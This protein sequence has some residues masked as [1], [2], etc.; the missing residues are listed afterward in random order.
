MLP[1]LG[2][3]RIRHDEVP[4]AVF[5]ILTKEDVKKR[6]LEGEVCP[7]THE[8]LEANRRRGQP[9]AT[10]RVKKRGGYD[11]YDAEALAQSVWADIKNKRRPQNPA[12]RQPLLNHDI[13]QLKEAFP[14]QK[15]PDDRLFEAIESRDRGDVERAIQAGASVR[16]ENDD[17]LMPLSMW[18]ITRN[19]PNQILF[20]LREAPDFDIDAKLNR[21]EATALHVAAMFRA[22]EPPPPAGRNAIQALLELNPNVDATDVKGDTVLHYFFEGIDPKSELPESLLRNIYDVNATN[23]ENDTPW[24]HAIKYVSDVSPLQSLLVS[25]RNAEHFPDLDRGDDKTA[26]PLHHAIVIA[27]VEKVKVLLL[28][29]ADPNKRQPNPVS[30]IVMQ[31]DG[32]PFEVAVKRF[33]D[34]ELDLDIERQ[35]KLFKI[36]CLIPQAPRYEHTTA[37]QDA[38]EYLTGTPRW[39]KFTKW[40]YAPPELSQGA[41]RPDFLFV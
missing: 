9:G 36:I 41:R 14:Y 33:D 39:K 37:N 2:A 8:E 7:I 21:N 28:A 29:G 16:A 24:F 10:F 13:R 34:P 6:A 1:N 11:W 4:T 40:P 22:N 19:C 23:N 18:A 25:V 31:P 26:S 38:A 15:S 35:R 3:L 32:S 5:K 17:G 20:A 27:S 12:N 30:S